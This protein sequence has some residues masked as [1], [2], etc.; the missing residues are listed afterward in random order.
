[1]KIILDTSLQGAHLLKQ[2]IQENIQAIRAQVTRHPAST[3]ASRKV[4]ADQVA[5]LQSIANV[6]A[7]QIANQ[8]D[9]ITTPNYGFLTLPTTHQHI[10]FRDPLIDY[11][12]AGGWFIL[13]TDQ[14]SYQVNRHSYM[15]GTEI[16]FK[17]KTPPTIMNHKA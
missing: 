11:W 1:M 9:L 16:R 4:A 6:L 14:L 17:Y 10:K 7:I 5:T 13:N 2:A 12:N 3:K 15:P 8:D